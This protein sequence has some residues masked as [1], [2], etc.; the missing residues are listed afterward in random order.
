MKSTTLKL[1]GIFAI[2]SAVFFSSCDDPCKDVNCGTNGTCDEE[3]GACICNSGYEGDACETRQTTKFVGNFNLTEVCTSGSDAYQCNIIESSSTVTS[4]SFSNLYNSGISV[5]ATVA[6][7]GTDFTIE[8]QT[9]GAGTITGSGSIN[10]AG[11]QVTVSYTVSVG[12]ASD[13]CAATLDR[14]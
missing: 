10:A 7:N 3:T 11:T 2:G 9:F 5:T 13:T 1:L 8:S 14:I 4:I 12:G 6:A